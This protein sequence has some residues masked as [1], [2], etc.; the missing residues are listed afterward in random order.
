MVVREK[1]KKNLLLVKYRV[2]FPCDIQIQKKKKNCVKNCCPGASPSTEISLRFSLPHIEPPR[3]SA[4][5][6]KVEFGVTNAAPE[7]PGCPAPQ[8]GLL[9]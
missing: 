5:P 6:F 4:Q 9:E 3:P 1:K 8:A 2:Y 7:G